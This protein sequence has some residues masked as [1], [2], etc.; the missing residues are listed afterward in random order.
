MSADRT[1]QAGGGPRLS[2]RA[3]GVGVLGVAVAGCAGD[4]P[5]GGPTEA[6]ASSSAAPTEAG[7]WSPPPHPR[8]I[9][10]E[11]ALPTEF[12]TPPATVITGA[13]VFDGEQLLEP[14]DVLLEGGLI[15][16]VGEVTRP[17]GVAVVEGEG[18]TLLPGLIDSHVHY[19]PPTDLLPGGLR[20]GVTTEIDLFSWPDQDLLEERR[21]TGRLEEP[22]IISAGYLATVPEGHP[23]GIDEPAFVGGPEEAEAW[24]AAR[25]EEG[26]ELIK[27]VVESVYPTLS[28]ETVAALV[29][30]GHSQGLMVVGHANDPEDVQTVVSAGCD[31]VVH[32]LSAPSW[33]EALLAE[34]VERQVF[35]VGTL[36]IAQDAD[37]RAILQDPLVDTLSASARHQLGRSDIHTS[38]FL[39]HEGMRATIQEAAAAGVPVLA[40]TDYYNP[41]TLPGIGM[42]VELELMVED[43][44][45]PLDA[46]RTATSAPATAWGLHDRG[47][48]QPGLR[49][50]LLLVEGDPAQD[51]TALRRIHRTFRLGHAVDAPQAG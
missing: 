45:S 6:G 50:D 12:E 46:L 10:P 13:R 24:V 39:D 25:L 49:A 26:S 17:G 31:G 22:D 36:G 32:A 33:P 41:G 1:G 44:M 20:Y 38:G 7:P 35:V 51:I 47:W 9:R 3:F 27:V 23:L 5:G 34:M 28:E 14:R 48:V 11:V 4:E 18:L 16:V 2:R 37:D 21:R 43:G 15:A 8:P 19:S 29:E 30:A 40:G 42:L